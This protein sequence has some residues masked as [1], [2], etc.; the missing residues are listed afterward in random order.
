MTD[1]FRP[2][3]LGP[4][5]APENHDGTCAQASGWD[6]FTDDAK[7][8][9]YEAGMRAG[10]IALA[11]ELTRKGVYTFNTHDIRRYAAVTTNRENG[12]AS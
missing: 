4:C 11:D 7:D 3:G 2:C 5:A 1:D 8:A 6:K 12:S 9:A 10:R